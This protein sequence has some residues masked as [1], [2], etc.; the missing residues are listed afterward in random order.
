MRGI[1]IL[2]VTFLALF[3]V[4]SSQAATTKQEQASLERA[5]NYHEARMWTEAILAFKKLMDFN[6][7]EA[8]NPE[9]HY[10]L[11]D[12]YLH[13]DNQA[14][15]A[16]GEEHFR[17]AI[18]LSLGQSGNVSKAIAYMNADQIMT[19]RSVI[20]EQV[21]KRPHIR[22]GVAR[23]L[24]DYGKGR[25]KDNRL[26]EA[27]TIFNLAS[28]YDDE[29]SRE[30]CDMLF[31]LGNDL[32]DT[33]APTYFAQAH[34]FCANSPKRMEI[35]GEKILRLA[36][37]RTGQERKELKGLA[38]WFLP[39]ERINQVVPPARWVVVHS[40]E[41]TGQ[42]WGE[43]DW[44]RTFNFGQEIAID[45]RIIVTGSQF[46]VWNTD[47]WYSHQRRH[48]TTNYSGTSGPLGVKAERGE[49]FKVTIERL[50]E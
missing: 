16:R 11:G 38:G 9:V 1:R 46:Q 32:G 23:Q 47:R 26:Q 39:D 37:Q 45:D 18:K 50:V 5:R 10:R 3:F 35:M 6:S 27:T 25:L 29:L 48:E 15:Q 12:C 49:K 4:A 20:D 2:V 14:D 8:V 13:L 19:A 28:F 33:A 22:K 7:K 30:A 44:V 34:S 42:G 43:N 41:Y 21:K 17:S 31:K 24:F 36:S 40:K